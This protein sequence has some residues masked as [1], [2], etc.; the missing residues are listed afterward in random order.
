[1]SQIEELHGRIT[2][3]MERIGAGLS[4][5][6]EQQVATAPDPGLAQALEQEQQANARLEDSLRALRARHDDDLAALRAELD[7]EAELDALRGELAVQADALR[8]LDKDLQRLRTANEQLRDSNA[9]LREANKSG[10][11]EPELINQAMQAE[12]EGLRATRAT[13]AAE[14]G[15]VLA[16]LE[17][18]LAQASVAPKGEEL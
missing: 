9:A 14:I 4:A 15:A 17:P 2:A 1:M 8:K 3:A 13:D 12:L 11:G 7:K 6:A 10:V 16:R 5:M 18:I